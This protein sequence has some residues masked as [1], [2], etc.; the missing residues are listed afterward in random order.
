MGP[1]GSNGETDEATSEETGTTTGPENL[2]RAVWDVDPEAFPAGEGIESQA[3]FLLRYAVLAP[4]SHNSQPW[5][6]AVDGG[7]V[8][9]SGDEERWLTATDPDM[10][11]FHLSIGCAVENLCVSAE[12]FGFSAEVTYTRAA[13]EDEDEDEGDVVAT[14]ALQPDGEHA[15]ARP[16]GLFEAI[17]E[18]ATSHAPFE[19]RPLAPGLRD[20]L[21]QCVEGDV[22]LL[23]VEDPDTLAAIGALQ[24]TADEALMN[25][26]AYRRE[27]GHWIGLGALGSGW[28]AA[29]VGRLVVT[30]LD[31]GAREGRKNATLLGSAPA[32]GVLATPSDDAIERVRAGR[33]FE[34]IALAA[35]AEGVDVH[36]KSQT[37]ERPEYRRQL[38]DLLDLDGARPQHLFRIGHAPDDEEH[39]PRWPVGSVL[40]E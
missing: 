5:A 17:T 33:V 21:E 18:R 25:D 35:T 32:V 6:F 8:A 16:P 14:V 7:T 12:R 13:D 26:P 1:D 20:R 38:A 40:R 15:A 23:V 31:L 30:H 9:V 27:L 4:S 24:A 2:T 34:R 3:R 29:R 39:T 22:E 10:R 19:E 28:L 11:E 36:P 37:L